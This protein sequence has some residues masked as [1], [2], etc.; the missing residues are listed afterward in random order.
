MSL[1]V[2][3]SLIS[4]YPSS[5]ISVLSPVLL[6][7]VSALSA[8]EV[9]M[10]KYSG[11]TGSPITAEC[12]LCCLHQPRGHS[13]SPCR[14]CEAALPSCAPFSRVRSRQMEEKRQRLLMCVARAEGIWWKSEDEGPNPSMHHMHMH[15]RTQSHKHTHSFPGLRGQCPTACKTLTCRHYNK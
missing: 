7:F 9:F 4:L 1:F 8:L 12:F 5:S 2:L 15:V 10:F 13:V 6:S 11:F 3:C 14:K